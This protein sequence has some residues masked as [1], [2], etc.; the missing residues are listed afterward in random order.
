V[1]ESKRGYAFG[2]RLVVDDGAP[3]GVLVTVAPDEPG[4]RV[5]EAMLLKHCGL[6]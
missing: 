6:N 4:R 5:L 3:D 2:V 1:G